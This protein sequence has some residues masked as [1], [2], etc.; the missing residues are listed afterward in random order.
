MTRNNDNNV[1]FWE[2][3]SGQ[4]FL[5]NSDKHSYQTIGC[6]FNHESF[7]ANIQQSDNVR[8]CKFDLENEAHWKSMSRMKLSLTKR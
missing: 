1:T 2:S 4:R 3:I 6:V 5:Q 7:Y 8:I